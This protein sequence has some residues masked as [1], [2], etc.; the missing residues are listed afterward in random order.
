MIEAL[1]DRYGD[2]T[3]LAFAGVLTGLV[4]G[5]AAQHSR[6]CLRAATVEVTDGVLGPRLA[7]WL[8]AFSAAVLSVQA[9]VAAG[10]FDPSQSRQLATTGSLSGAIIGGGMFGCGMILAR[11][12]ASRLLVL[13]ATGNLR[14]LLTGLVLTIVAQM[15]LRGALSPLRETLANLWTIDGG[16][17]RDLL[18]HLRLT[19][20][21]AAVLSAVALGVSLWLG[22]RHT[23]Q[24]SHTIAAVIVGGAIGLGWL[25]TYAI[26]E[27]SFGVVPISSVTFT[28]PS[29]DTLMGLVN[30]RALPLSFGIGL[31]PGVFV[32]A[33]LMALATREA[34][35]ERFGPKTPMERYLIGAVLMGFGSMLAGGCAVGA[36]MSGGAVFAVT[37]WIAVTCMWL[38]AMATHRATRI[39][40]I[41]RPVA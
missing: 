9:F 14:A 13:S 15:S 41:T 11:G 16:S 12:C 8:I 22:R 17:T 18:S 4:F 31:V 2:G 36:G 26:A 40:G 33:A 24:A 6:F 29:A 21:A 23:V 32:G 38:G 37:A 25:L 5:A 27:T 39:A 19:S 35:I 7:I 3:V 30:N 34:R 1:L 10:W 28:G 20:G